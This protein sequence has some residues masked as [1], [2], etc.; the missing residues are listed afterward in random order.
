MSTTGFSKVI[1]SWG[2]MRRRQLFT[3]GPLPTIRDVLRVGFSRHHSTTVC[4]KCTGSAP[5]RAGSHLFSRL[6]DQSGNV[7]KLKSK[8]I[9]S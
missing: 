7:G 9:F 5:N 4:L 8:V 6:I 3:N 1:V 2:F